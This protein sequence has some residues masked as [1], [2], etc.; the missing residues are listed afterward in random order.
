MPATPTDDDQRAVVRAACR[1][2]LA[3]A[4]AD[5][6][7]AGGYSVQT[8]V[9]SDDILLVAGAAEAL[10]A[11]VEAAH[12]HRVIG[13]THEYPCC[14][15]TDGMVSLDEALRAAAAPPSAEGRGGDE[16]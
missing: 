15:G 12:P 9:W 6:G 2:L 10:L 1:R 3:R 13:H 8:M 5:Q 16:E 7:E 11:A 4:R 14:I